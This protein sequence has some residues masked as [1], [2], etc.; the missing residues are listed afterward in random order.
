MIDADFVLV[1]L[2]RE[3]AEDRQLVGMLGDPRHL[4]TNLDAGH[5]RIDRLELTANAVGGVRLHVPHVLLRRA[6]PEIDEDTGLGRAGGAA[7][8]AGARGQCLLRADQMRQ[9]ERSQPDLAQ[10]KHRIVLC[11]HHV[12]RLQRGV[13]RRAPLEIGMRLD[14]AKKFAECLNEIGATLVMHGHRHVSERRVAAGCEFEV[15]AAPSFTLGCVSGDGP[16]YWR[17]ELGERAHAER[18]HV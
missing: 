8:G 18:A 15:L 1:A 10:A 4:V 16:S 14:D 13:G 2:V 12:A 17:V 6:A 3:G 11:H 5:D 9:R 7:C